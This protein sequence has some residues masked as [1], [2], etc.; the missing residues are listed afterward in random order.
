M[1]ERVLIAGSGYLF[2]GRSRIWGYRHCR[3]PGLICTNTTHAP[4]RRMYYATFRLK[5]DLL[6]LGAISGIGSEGR[7][8]FMFLRQ[9]MNHVNP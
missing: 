8:I 1:A 4:L 2:L 6:D 7:Y 5:I 3:D 9:R